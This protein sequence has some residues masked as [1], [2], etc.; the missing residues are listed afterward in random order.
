M[1]TA[2]KLL[3]MISLA[4]PL[5]ANLSVQGM[6]PVATEG[7]SLVDLGK[8]GRGWSGHATWK[9]Q[10]AQNLPLI[11]TQVQ[12]GC[13]CV[14][15]EVDR[16][17]LEKG[18]TATIKA[19]IRTLSQPEGLVSWRLKVHYRQGTQMGTMDLVAK[20][21]LVGDLICEP[22]IL[23]FKGEGTLVVPLTLKDRRKPGIEVTKVSAGLKGI[24]AD[25]QKSGPGDN[26]I[27]VEKLAGPSGHQKGYLVLETNDPLYPQLEI[28]V[29]LETSSTQKV[30]AAPSVIQFSS[31]DRCRVLFSRQGDLLVR[32]S[33][34]HLPQGLAAKISKG[35]GPKSTI[36]F[37][38]TGPIPAGEKVLVEFENKQLPATE[39]EINGP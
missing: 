2:A 17:K 16:N 8:I 37:T 1:R 27:R 26:L 35:P 12:P 30:E 19:R 11:I 28:P 25:L 7:G 20:A 4:S 22:T 29:Q 38:K 32:V 6:N 31:N 24:K 23:V 18:E 33:K 34:V 13:H 21:E 15:P 5:L 3:F 14:E 9:I 36:E 39:L 10:N